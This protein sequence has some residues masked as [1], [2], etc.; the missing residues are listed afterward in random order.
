MKAWPLA[1]LLAACQPESHA[2]LIIS[3]GGQQTVIPYEDFAKCSITADDLLRQAK[4]QSDPN[5]RAFCIV[6]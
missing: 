2:K 5:F 3:E 1:L 6:T 4:A